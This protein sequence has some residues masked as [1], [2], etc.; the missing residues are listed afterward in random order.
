MVRPADW[1]AAESVRRA[2]AGG[3]RL[4]DLWADAR[5]RRDLELGLAVAAALIDRGHLTDAERVLDELSPLVGAE[6]RPVLEFLRQRL[7]VV[8]EEPLDLPALEAALD[9]LLAGARWEDALH[10]ASMIA[11]ARDPDLAAVR[12]F[13]AIAV[14]AAEAGGARYL[15]AVQL[16]L[17]AAAELAAG[18]VVRCVAHL[19]QAL[20]RLADVP[21]LGARLEEALCHELAG[22]A[23]ASAGDIAAA[24]EEYDRALERLPSE[25]SGALRRVAG[26]RDALG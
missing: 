24:R 25:H 9:G 23:L 15:G 26:K 19:E 13:R 5:T 4:L 11:G 21:L 3:R 16:R 2:L 12:R 8:R 18:E 1:D 22:D 17:L 14:G 7:R 6:Q 10:A 20:R